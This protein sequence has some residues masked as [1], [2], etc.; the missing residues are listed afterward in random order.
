MTDKSVHDFLATAFAVASCGHVTFGAPDD[1]IL[2]VC[3]LSHESF[4]L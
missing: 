2:S 4:M 1:L 3:M